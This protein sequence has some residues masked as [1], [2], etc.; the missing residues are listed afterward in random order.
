MTSEEA[1]ARVE[2]EPLVQLPDDLYIPPE[3]LEVFLESFEGPL[4]LLLYLIH[5]NRLDITTISIQAVAGQ[6][7][8][9][10]ELM[11]QTR[12]DLAGEYLVMAATL[13]ELKSRSLLPRPAT[14]A[15]EVESDPRTELIRRLQE[16]ERFKEASE[17]LDRQPRAGRDFY[18]ARASLATE[19]ASPQAEA[20]LPEL[21]EALREILQRSR[22]HQDHTI[23]SQGLSVRER[24]TE[25][26]SRL[27]E[28]AS[29][30][31]EELL[32]PTEGREG[33]AVTFLALLELA[34]A[35]LV[36]LFQVAPLYPLHIRKP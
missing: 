34:K 29:F 3:A 8:E 14:E 16:Y 5:R 17:A 32:D 31:L 7:L 15:E 1:I 4:D 28:A 11:R 6:Y 36:E 20:S 10:V 24:M 26:L 12:L 33:L 21:L 27:E 2:G 23:E 35:Q 13:A 9:Y 18:V 25:I 19:V 30:Q 22:F